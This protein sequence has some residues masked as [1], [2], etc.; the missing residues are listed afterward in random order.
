MEKYYSVEA[1]CGHVGKGYYIPIVFPVR[2]ISKEEAA[3]IARNLPRVKHHHK[4]TILQV[5]EISRE[6]YMSLRMQNDSDPYLHCKN[7]Q[8]QRREASAIYD[9]VVAE[10]REEK[11]DLRKEASGTV[12]YC[13]KEPI[14]N[15]RKYLREQPD[16]VQLSTVRSTIHAA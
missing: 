7:I 14:R 4:D 12:Y 10:A 1:K 3:S 15:I 2:A 16:Q 11:D 6:G 8:E 9:R 13:G 5:Q